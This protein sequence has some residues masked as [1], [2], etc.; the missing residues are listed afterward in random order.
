MRSVAPILIMAGGT[1][2]HVFP[3]LAVAD[4][5]RARGVPVIWLGTR[6]G[7]EARLV[8]QAGYPIEWLSISGWRGKGLVNSLLAPVRLT[9]ACFQAGRVLLKKRPCA[10]LGMGGFASGP[11]G[12]MAW[13]MRKPLLIPEQNAVAGLTN[14]LLARVADEVMEA[15]PGTLGKKALYVGNPVRRQIIAIVSPQQRLAGRDNGLRLLVI[16]GSLGAVRLNEL[17]PEAI[18]KIEPA[19]RPQV[20]HPTGVKTPDAAQ[21]QYKKFAVE[22]RAEA[23]VDDMAAAYAW[24]DVVICRAGAMTVFELAAAGVAS[25]LVPYPYAVDDHQTANARYLEEVDAAIVRQQSDMDSEWLRVTITELSQQ[26]DRLLRMAESARS[27]AKPTAAGEVAE[28]CLR[29]GGLL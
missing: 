24:A 18:S 4:E 2:G 13:L 27:Q 7:I 12:L 25:I 26:R 19:A 22:A 14:R 8:P 17:V 23:F 16:G 11:G 9:I 3:A 6:A 15:F 10:V 5:L 1:G 28:R 29:A 21:A 20:W